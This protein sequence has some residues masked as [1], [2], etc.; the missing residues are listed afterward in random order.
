MLVYQTISSLAQKEIHVLCCCVVDRHHT[1]RISENLFVIFLFIF[2]RA[3]RLLGSAHHCKALKPVLVLRG[4]G[5][6]VHSS[7]R[8]LKN[9]LNELPQR[10]KRAIVGDARAARRAQEQQDL[11]L[12]HG[13]RQVGHPS[14][15]LLA[16]LVRKYSVDISG[17]LFYAF[18][19]VYGDFELQRAMRSGA[20]LDLQFVHLKVTSKLQ[21]NQFERAA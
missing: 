13:I 6:N 21:S 20:Y 7:Q 14:T 9:V 10:C 4:G 17:D 3:R 5:G 19:L 11:V 18:L 2:G 15:K 8:H 1:L 16:Q 12:A